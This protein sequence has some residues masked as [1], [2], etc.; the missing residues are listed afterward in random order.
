MFQKDKSFIIIFCLKHA[1]KKK[2]DLNGG[3]HLTVKFT[4][5]IKNVLT[6]F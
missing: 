5:F 2:L 4:A 6:S 1:Q 3:S